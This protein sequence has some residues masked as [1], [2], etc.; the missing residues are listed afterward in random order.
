MKIKM[1]EWF[2]GT[3]F[4]TLKEGETYGVGSGGISKGL[5]DWLIEHGKAVFLE[6]EVEKP[7]PEPEPE[8][9]PEPIIEPEP[10]PALEPEP[11]LE[12]EPTP[13]PAPEKEQE[14]VKPASP[15]VQNAYVKKYNKKVGRK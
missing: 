7:A 5:A 11:V 15:L 14:E 13:E 3:G 1:K 6:E 4:P 8:P 9:E 10:E 12:P 2:Q